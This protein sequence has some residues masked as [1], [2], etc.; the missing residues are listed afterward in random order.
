MVQQRDL[1]RQSTGDIA[2]RNRNLKDLLKARLPAR[3]MR[4]LHQIGMIADER[5]EPIFLVGGVVRDLLLDR[6]NWDL[7]VAVEGDGI[8][9]ARVVADRYKAGMAL[10]ERFATARLV[11]AHGLKLDIAS[12]RRES[13]AQPAALP[14]VKPALLREDLHRRDFTFNAIALQLNAPQF[15]LLYDYYGGLRDLHAGKLRVLHE[16]SFIDDP[17]RVFRAIRF[18]HRF[19][20]HLESKTARLLREIAATD[21]IAQLSGPRLRTEMLLLADEAHPDRTLSSC[22]RLNLFRFLHRDLRYGPSARRL[23]RSL[24]GAMTWWVTRCR[25]FPIDR[26]VAYLMALLTEATP[27]IVEGVITRLMLSNEQAR[28]VRAGGTELMVVAQ[29]LS[30][31]QSL[32]RSVVYRLLNGLPDEALLLCLARMEGR[33]AAS[34]RVKRRM[35]DYLTKSSAVKPVL[36]GRD[37]LEMGVEAG[38]EVGMLLAQ[39]LEAKLDGLLKGK[40]GERAFVRARLAGKT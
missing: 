28:K 1:T 12:T 24:A 4:L 38:P 34:A 37:L 7:D 14:D 11:L 13:Y 18:A 6:P 29:T 2:M 27:E 5:H 33:A 9:F 20:F 36:R 35:L 21:V 16:R 10:F 8:A 40:A 15:G 17:T 19:G 22:A 32:K 31:T 39:L 23:V 30:A 26:P 25:R 3:I